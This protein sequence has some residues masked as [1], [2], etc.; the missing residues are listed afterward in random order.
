[1][2]VGETIYPRLPQIVQSG[3]LNVEAWR[4]QRRRFGRDF[5]RAL[6]DAESRSYASADA[7]RHHRRSRLAS[8]LV[9]CSR[10]VPFYRRWFQENAIDPRRD[11]VDVIVRRLPIVTKREVKAAL[12]DYASEAAPR[13]QRLVHTSGT[14]GEGFRFFVSP[15]VLHE[16]WAVWWRYRRWHGLSLNTWCGYFGGRSVV[17]IDQQEPPFWRINYAGR[18]VMFSGYHLSSENLRH[19]VGE[20]NRR[21]P[22][23][24]HGYPSLLAL[25][26]A[27]VLDRGGLEYQPRWITTGAE[28]LLP[29]QR[30]LIARAFG[31]TPR[32]HY[33][34]AEAV[35]NVSECER[36]RLHVDEDFSDFELV[37]GGDGSSA[38]IVGTSFSNLAMGFVRYDTG[39]LARW[40]PETCDCGRA[41]RVIS[42]VDG[43]N[44]DYVVL[45]NGARL[46]RL[47]HVFKDMVHV[48]EAQI[49]QRR[50]GELTLRIVR[51]EGFGSSDEERLL[52]EIHARVGRDAEVTVEYVTALERSERGKLRFV[53]SELSEGRCAA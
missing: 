22:P 18:Q 13:D 25:V 29:Q 35:A 40:S 43:R 46:G 1:M 44:E 11:D 20:L 34:H 47:D 5:D 53:I 21:R 36:G 2:S 52:R 48:R 14:T 51:G 45:K 15:D 41:G 6:R 32:Q 10:T 50:R 38:R 37:A 16:Q 9:Y 42:G 33:G 23:W 24:L 27:H 31:V 8:Y 3:I 19:V 39:D 28:N 26:A 7:L 12:H 30:T 17:P 49:H 4:I